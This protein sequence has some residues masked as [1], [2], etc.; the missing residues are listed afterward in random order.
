MKPS[1][2]NPLFHLLASVAASV[3]LAA[4]A[5]TVAKG[6]E[7]TLLAKPQYKLFSVCAGKIS[8]SEEDLRLIARNFEFLHG[9]FSPEQNAAI[10]KLNPDIKCLIYINS[11]Y[12]RTEEDVGIVES[13]YRD[14]LCMLL[15]ARLVDPIDASRTNFRVAPTGAKTN[16]GGEQPLIPIRASTIEGDSSSTERGRPGTQFYVFWI[17]IGNEL[18]RVS[19]FD[20]ASGEIE[21]TRGFSGSKP[22]VHQANDHIFSPVYLGF[23]RNRIGKED[24]LVMGREKYPGNHPGGPGVQLRYA[25][26]ANFQRGYMYQ[27]QVALDA[28]RENGA[29]GVWMD[30]FNCGTFNLSDCLGRAA[31]PWDFVKNQEYAFDDF[32]LGQEKKVTFI[33]EFLRAQLGKF[34]ILVANNLNDDYEVG[35]GGMKLLLMPTEVKPRPLDAFCMEGGLAIRSAKVWKERLQVLADAAQNG[36]AAAPIWANAGSFSVNSERDT[37]ERDQAERFGYASYLLAVEKDGKTLMGTY[38]FW[39][40]E[41]KRFV[42]I[43][44]MY[45]Y[46]IGYPT[47]TQKPDQLDKYLFKDLPVYRRSFTNGVVLVNPSEKDCTVDLDKT[48]LDPDT[49]KLV[50]SVALRAGTGK[51]LLKN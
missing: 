40:A 43:H 36:L 48:Y 21:V 44:P 6:E 12:T 18:M 2:L 35:R 32:R 25:L 50:A 24:E 31:R 27:A 39:Q 13:K 11:T 22:A 16:A 46:P 7:F 34:P 15:A 38:A 41:G 49:H 5:Q 8:A 26:D 23:K 37:P 51:I 20:P 9:K 28:I 42:K 4:E 29:D 19:K 10:R 30:T 17:R 33:Q 14:A 3:G 1:P 45:F 47:E